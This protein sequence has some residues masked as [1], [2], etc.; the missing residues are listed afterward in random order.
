MPQNN[1]AIELS[2]SKTPFEVLFK[3]L[4]QDYGDISTLESKVEFIVELHRAIEALE[5]AAENSLNLTTWG[6]ITCSIA[7][8]AT[9]I[10]APALAPFVAG[11]L[12]VSAGA[13]AAT[14]IGASVAK[15]Q[16]ES[17]VVE[18]LQKYRLAITSAEPLEWAVVWHCTSIDSFIKS[19]HQASRGEVFNGRLMRRNSKPAFND[20]VD[21]SA[22][23]S[24][25]SVPDFIKMLSAVKSGDSLSAS[26]PV[27]IPVS[28]Q[29]QASPSP[30]MGN[31]RGNAIAIRDSLVNRA[32]DS[33]LGGCVI[34]AAPGAGKTTFLGSAWGHLKA[35]HGSNFR[36]LALV[37]KKSDVDAFRGVSDK[38]LCVKSGVTTAAVAIIK[39][40]DASTNHTGN[41]SRLFLDDFLTMIKYFET[42]LKGKLVDPETFSVFDSR[43]EASESDCLDA[44]PM[45]DH[46]LTLLNEFWLVGREYNSAVWVSSHSSN[47]QDLPFMGSASARSVGDLIFLAKNGKRE[48]IELALGNNF[49]ISD[50]KK[51]QALKSQLDE[52]SIESDE[53]IV[54][55]NFNNWTLGIVS[56]EIYEEYQSFRKLWEVS[57]VPQVEIQDIAPRN[58]PQVV[59]DILPKNIPQV[60]QPKFVSEF[61]LEEEDEENISVE[62]VEDINHVRR[63][64]E[65]LTDREPLTVEAQKIYTKL[66]KVGKPMTI[67]ELAQATVLGKKG[68]NSAASL[69][70]YLGELMLANLVKESNGF[71]RIS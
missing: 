6:S 48:F 35:K 9:L 64:L 46:M 11:I 62:T 41:I 18:E 59:R 68:N 61:Q 39:F 12:S 43:K 28:P 10:L 16:I 49:L 3:N 4:L 53:P 31:L 67:R 69:K 52:I 38:C 20:A 27:H 32:A 44:V 23:V 55:G 21:Y 33:V 40:I 30:V 71:Y 34:L 1:S 70:F 58:V 17:R 26:I 24:R 56:K 42:G 15:H 66:I 8:V 60:Q 45:Y 19:L 54:L 5:S 22:S 50:N 2:N 36:S 14:V 37:V 63:F 47:V 25:K 57:S 13:S 51:R 7:G 65:T 29:I